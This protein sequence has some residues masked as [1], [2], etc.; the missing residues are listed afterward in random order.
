MVDNTIQLVES[1]YIHFIES[2]ITIA[3]TPSYHIIDKK[4]ID[5]KVEAWHEVILITG[6]DLKELGFNVKP[7]DIANFFNIKTDSKFYNVY[8]RSIGTRNF[9]YKALISNC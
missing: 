6:T 4:S 2:G 5:N 7:K 9:L 8:L 3:T 1:S